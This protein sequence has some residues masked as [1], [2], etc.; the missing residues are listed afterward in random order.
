MMTTAAAQEA[1][2]ADTQIAQPAPQGNL[3]ELFRLLEDDATR[4]ELLQLLRQRAGSGEAG[5][6]G[7]NDAEAQAGRAEGVIDPTI[8]RQVAEYTRGIAEG[9]SNSVSSIVDVVGDVGEL[10]TSTAEADLG[11]LGSTMTNLLILGGT[12]FASFLVL[13]LVAARIQHAIA[14]RMAGASWINRSGGVLGAALVDLA[15]VILAWAAGYFVALNFLPGPFG[16]MQ[17]NQTLLLNAFLVVETIKVVLRA[18]FE[19]RDPQLRFL[20]MSDTTAAYWYFWVGRLISLVGYTFMFVA[21]I[22]AEQLTPGAAQAV[23]VLVMTTSVLIG[24]LIILQNKT[25]VREALSARSRAGREDALSRSLAMIGAYWHLIAMF[26]LIA[27]LVVWL[28]NPEEALPFMLRATVQSIIAIAVGAFVITFIS[29]FINAGLR[30]PD[31]VKERLPLLETRLQAFVP[32]VMQIVRTIVLIAVII[33]IAQAWALLDFMGWVATEAGQ[34]ATGALISAA[35]IILAGFVAYL[36]MS[37]W[38]EYRLNPNFGS[39]P[40]AREKTLLMLFR[41]AFTIALAVMV[42]MLA[43]AQIG[44]NIAPLLAGAGVL[45]LAIGFGAQKF[46][47]DIITGIFIQFENIM[48]EGD[49]VA[50]AGLTGVVER[51]TIRS[52]SIRSLD[53]T[54]H[55]IPF[56]SVDSVSNMMKGFSYHVA[57]MGVAYREDIGEVKAAMQ[58]AYD[59]LMETDHRFHILEPLDIQGVTSFGDSAV[60][61]R[62]RIKTRPGMQWG[63]GRA[64]NEILKQVFDRHGIEIPFPHMTLYMGED[65]QGRSPPLNLRRTTTIEEQPLEGPDAPP[66][67]YDSDSIAEPVNEAREMEGRSSG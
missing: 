67:E 44:V 57:E 11:R 60:M 49:V 16:R 35:F 56:S 19:P 20:P 2:A 26:Y 30:L 36:A 12:L 15:A 23:R 4:A 59:I 17:I 39:V 66:S 24:I 40:T 62:A 47:Q 9:L 65:K 14:G 34:R 31:D 61:V 25:Q 5:A 54:V 45:G 1:P 50:V 46:V 33:A 58:E 37:S 64:Y 21:P 8:A 32:R 7:A 28:T 27:L 63:T 51:L 41:N 29:R 43:L 22:I 42:G 53:G 38:V 52:V 55:L 6:P 3:E 48:N 13:R 18:I 10:F